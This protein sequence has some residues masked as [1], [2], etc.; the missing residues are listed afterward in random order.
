[1]RFLCLKANSNSLHCGCEILTV[2]RR[3]GPDTEVFSQVVQSGIVQVFFIHRIWTREQDVLLKPCLSEQIM[4]LLF[5]T[6][7]SQLV[8]NRSPSKYRTL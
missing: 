5:S 2:L 8:A 7:F 1:V 6:S 3:F 4:K